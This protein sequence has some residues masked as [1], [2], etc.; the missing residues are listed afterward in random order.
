[1]KKPTRDEYNAIGKVS[2]LGILIIGALGF[3]IADILKLV[4]G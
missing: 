3:V 2:A 4:V 1:L